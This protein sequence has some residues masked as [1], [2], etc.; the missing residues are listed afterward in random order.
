MNETT[1]IKKAK[2]DRFQSHDYYNIDELLQED[3]LLARDAV[4]DLIPG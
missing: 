2:E 3:H 1:V 4:R